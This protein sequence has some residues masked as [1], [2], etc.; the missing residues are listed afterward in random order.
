MEFG[1]S[2]LTVRK[3]KAVESRQSHDLVLP[4]IQRVFDL[5]LENTDKMENGYR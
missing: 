3:Q 5:S 2:R 4:L 1:V